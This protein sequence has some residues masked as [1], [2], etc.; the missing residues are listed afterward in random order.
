MNPFIKRYI[1]EPPVF[2]PLAVLFHLFLL[3]AASFSFAGEPMD[4]GMWYKLIWLA[5]ALVFAL[6]ICDFRKWAAIGYVVLTG[7]G[8]ALQYFLP[9]HHTWRYAAE[10]AF[11]FD[12]IYTGL[13]LF[14]FRRFQ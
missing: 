6:F 10:A 9:Q 8:L 11:P 14:F 5:L 7:T 3:G 1:T 13:L 12:V 2:F 4:A